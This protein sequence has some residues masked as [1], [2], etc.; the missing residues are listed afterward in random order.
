MPWPPDCK[1][2]TVQV[3]AAL[4]QA[5]TGTVMVTGTGLDEVLQQAVQRLQHPPS[6]CCVVASDETALSAARSAGQ[7]GTAFH[8]FANVCCLAL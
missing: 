6:A 7:L 4:Q 2:C 1:A 3:E 8:A 5:D